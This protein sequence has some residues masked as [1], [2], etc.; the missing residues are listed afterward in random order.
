MK[1]PIEKL[2][3][4]EVNT[5]PRSC[6][7]LLE[8]FEKK[9]KLPKGEKLKFEGI[10]NKD[11]YNITAPFEIDGTF[12]IA[13]RVEPRSTNLD[14]QVAFFTEKDGVWRRDENT[15][16]FKLEDPFVTKI[17]RE[18]IFGGV[19]TY[20]STDPAIYIEGLG[21]RTI[22][23]RGDNLQ[24]LKRF[25]IGPEIMKDIRLVDLSDKTIGVFTRPQGKIGNKGKIGFI[26]INSIDQL[27]AENILRAKLIQN[28]F[29]EDEWGS[30]NEAHQLESGLIDALGHIAYQDIDKTKHYFAMK[31]KFNPET[32]EVSPLEIIAKRSDFPEG[33][34]KR[35]DLKDVVFPGGIVKN[36]DQSYTLYAGLSDAETGRINIPN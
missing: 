11:V 6:R 30:V 17:G 28:Q 9:D 29:S 16:I 20:P 13:G 25:V 19:Q 24:N 7:E 4:E 27:N 32:S 12:Y 33:E 35:P 15:P 8:V 22:F 3:A 5:E 26:R 14:A 31:F 21:Y 2:S 34:A 1:S 18:I 10:D 36:K 23:Y